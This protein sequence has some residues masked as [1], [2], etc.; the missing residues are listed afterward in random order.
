MLTLQAISRY[1]R[2]QGASLSQFGLPEPAKVDREV[3]I[4]LDAFLYRRDVLLQ[5][6]WES[7][8]MMNIE[9]RSIY[10]R[11]FN[12]RRYFTILNKVKYPTALAASPPPTAS[13]WTETTLQPLGHRS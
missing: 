6:G 4:E 7:Y 5:Q 13:F 10:G 11:I 3:N 12:S 2:S 9:Q 8:E 1:L